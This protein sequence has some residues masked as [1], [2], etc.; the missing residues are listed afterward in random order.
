M[1]ISLANFKG[2]MTKSCGVFFQII[3]KLAGCL[4]IC[5]DI[6]AK[7]A[8]NMSEKWDRILS[9]LKSIDEENIH[10]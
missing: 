5:S 9:E 4:Y 8:Q 10:M 3:P 7:N 6:Y 2:G 1:C